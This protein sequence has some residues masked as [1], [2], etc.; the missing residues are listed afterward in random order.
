MTGASQ[1]HCQGAVGA[2]CH[3]TK[4]GGQ[5]Q[6]GQEVREEGAPHQIRL[7]VTAPWDYFCISSVVALRWSVSNHEAVEVV[8]TTAIRVEGNRI[9]GGVGGAGQVDDAGA[10]KG[11]RIG[12]HPL[13]HASEQQPQS[14][15]AHN[16]VEGRHIDTEAE[17]QPREGEPEG[18][19]DRN[20]HLQ[21]HRAK[22]GELSGND[23]APTEG[24]ADR[25]A[26]ARTSQRQCQRLVDSDCNAAE[27]CSQCPCRREVLKEVVTSCICLGV[28]VSWHGTRISA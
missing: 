18:Q 14:D 15:R 8:S 13:H 5:P 12:H 21:R 9:E 27:V 26:M 16:P 11:C 19:A 22:D 17:D 7:G 20:H 2:D 4:V 23:A 10:S 6:L 25:Q 28:T 3:S 1:R 24:E